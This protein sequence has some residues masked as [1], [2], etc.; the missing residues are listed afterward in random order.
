MSTQTVNSTMRMTSKESKP[1]EAN[2][3]KTS[4]VVDNFEARKHWSIGR[5]LSWHFRQYWHLWLMTIPGMAFVAIF[6]YVPMYGLQL[7][8]KEF[9]PKKGLTG[10]KFVG[11]KYFEKFVTSPLFGEIMGNTVNIALWTLLT[12]FIAPIIL[13]LLLNQMQNQKIKSFVQT[14]TYM[15]HFISIV[16][17]VSMVTLFLTPGTGLL[18]RVFGANN[19]L[20]SPDAF[21]HIYWISGVWQS[22]GWS[23]I[24]Y[25]AALSSVDPGLYEAAKIDGA[26]RLQLIRH[27]DI[28][29]I[30]PTC[31]ILLI[32]NMGHVLN[33]GFDK[34]FLMQNTMNMPASEVIST[35]VYKV[36]MVSN[37]FSYSTA[38]G[39]FNTIINFIFLMLANGISR[40][41]SDTSIF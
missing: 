24:I 27:V 26:N 21:V 7:A 28:P 15:P 12:G 22:C 6:A 35:Y 2:G 10:G 36:G 17:L 25:L 5:K 18:G 30:L 41:V 16:V 11:L 31:V 13:A 20:A 34:T 37:Q 3:T 33:V 38:I 39:L 14:I 19:L 23:A 32:M 4:Q 1:I 8:F 9:T 29:T 40:R